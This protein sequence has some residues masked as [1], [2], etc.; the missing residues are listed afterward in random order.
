MKLKALLLACAVAG[1]GASFALADDGHG[2][3]HHDSSTTSSTSTGT[4]ATTTTT[5]TTNS[6]CQRVELRGKL[7]SVSATSFTIDV[8]KGNDAAQALVGHT[9]TV[10]VVA[11]TRVEWSGTGTLTGPNVGD[12]ARVRACATGSTLTAKSVSSRGPRAAG[13]DDFKK[14]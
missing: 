3:Q 12:E 14:H 1:A 5:T 8:T 2:K 11:T 7:A 13:H 6:D 10:G 9:A 4:N